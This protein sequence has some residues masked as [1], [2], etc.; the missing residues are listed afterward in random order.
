MLRARALTRA[1]GGFRA[2]DGIDLDVEAGRITGLIGPNGAGKTTSFNLLAGALTPTSGTILLDDQPIHHLPP[3][4]RAALGLGRTFQIP[5]PFAEMTVLENVMTAAKNQAGEVFWRNWLLRGRIAAEERRL[6]ERA[7][8]LI[9]FVGL[10]R[11]ERDP[12]RTLS[13]GQRKLLELARVMMAEPRLVLLDEPAAGVNPT[14]LTVLV[15]K[16]AA[17][18]AQG[19]TFLIIEHNMDLIADLCD[20]VVVMAQGRILTTG[21]PHAVQRDSRVIDAYLGGVAA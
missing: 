16:I 17:L 1:F 7:R 13:G 19:V 21:T 20:P 15:D 18:N 9:A 11:V 8:H 5:R 6:A 12:A 3:H 4:R 14:L 10:G 2:V